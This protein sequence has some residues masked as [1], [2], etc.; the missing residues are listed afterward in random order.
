MGTFQ[1]PSSKSYLVLFCIFAVAQIFFTS[2]ISYGWSSIAVVFR[3]EKYFFELCGNDTNHNASSTGPQDEIPGCEAQ[4]HILNLIVTLTWF[5]SM[6]MQFPAG[7]L[8]DRWGPRFGQILGLCFYIPAGIWF[9]M[10]TPKYPYSLFGIFIMISIGS[11]WLVLSAYKV[12]NV[13]YK[14][15][16]SRIMCIL[17]GTYDSSAVF[18]LIF[19]VAYDHHIS[20]KYVLV[21]YTALCGIIV[22]TGAIFLIPSLRRLRYWMSSLHSDGNA[23]E[24]STGE[25]LVAS[26]KSY[27]AIDATNVPAVQVVNDD[28]DD[29]DDNES[30]TLL[31]SNP[32]NVKDNMPASYDAHASKSAIWASVSSPLYLLEIAF[33]AAIQLKLWFFVGTLSDRLIDMSHNDKHVVNK[34]IYIFGLIQFSGLAITTLCGMIFD[35]NRIFN[36]E[37]K[38]LSAEEFRLQRMQESITPFLITLVLSILMS[39][40][41]MLRNMS[42]QIPLFILYTLVR[43]FLYSSYGAYIGSVFPENQFG[44]LF[45]LG[46]FIA[47]CFGLLEY[48]LFWLTTDV[49]HDNPFWPDTIL[50]ILIVLAA[51]HP[52]YLYLHC[53]KEDNK[54]LTNAL[55]Q[56]GQHKKG[57]NMEN[58][59]LDI[60]KSIIR[61]W[62]QPS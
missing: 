2:G 38:Y 9:T 28:N 37:T 20:L 47:G 61:G 15:A 41:T 57:E 32:S 17:S 42:V 23:L 52:L 53:K 48:F 29:D 50:L 11:S 49:F 21:T 33:L 55:E 22:A 12:V 7:V 10:T 34:Y 24:S 59:C 43:G 54:I 4:D 35:R 19:K 58:Y 18:M 44:T 36:I 26:T 31:K 1:H 14:G 46:I 3:M 5:T 27:G 16:R 45:G 25:N 6:F 40:G 13:V 51:I 62:C 39:V 60:M 30:T 56:S 8:V